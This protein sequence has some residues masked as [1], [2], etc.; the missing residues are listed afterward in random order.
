MFCE[1]HVIINKG[2]V[3]INISHLHNENVRGKYTLL[4]EDSCQK[5]FVSI[6]KRGLPLK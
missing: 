2:R 3:L 5:Y 4:T 1:A 6:L